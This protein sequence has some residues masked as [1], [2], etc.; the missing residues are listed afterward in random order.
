[1]LQQEFEVIIIGGGQA[2]LA[3]GY[4]LKQAKVSFLI[5]EKGK[6]VGD[7]WRKRY[8]S[9][10]LFTP[11]WYSSLPGL[12]LKGD[13][14]GYASKDEIADYLEQYSIHFSLPIQVNTEILMLK[15]SAFG[16]K[17]TTNKGDYLAQKVIIATGPFQKPFIPYFSTNIS[18][19]VRQLHT[20]EY[21]NPL[22]LQEGQVL[23]VGAGNSGAQIAVEL[24][25]QTE[26]ALSLG[27]QLKFMPLELFG[28]SIF[29]WF[30]KTGILRARVNSAI[31]KRL[32]KM[33]DPIFGYELRDRFRQ[34]KVRLRARTENIASDIAIFRDHTRLQIK[35]VIW[36]TG[37]IRDYSWIHIPHVLDHKSMPVHDRGVSP[38]PGLF[39]LGLPWQYRRGSALI[40]GVGE[41]AAYIVKHILR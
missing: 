4:Y 13:P 32:K 2:G 15:K 23:I 31:G 18:Q 41:D 24:S 12:L 10:V 27:H 33:G 6:A 40:G 16:F 28:K 5:L 35:N 19:E 1:M 29:W 34:G 38:V 20:S 8:D 9:L 25:D 37:F 17:V 3:A 22:Q 26:V 39:F 21:R 14:D 30:Q 11:R 7:S 36:A